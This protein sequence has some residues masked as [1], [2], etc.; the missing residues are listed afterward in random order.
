MENGPLIFILLLVAFVCFIM[1]YDL[2]S[3]YTKL[4]ENFREFMNKNLV[5][6]EFEMSPLHAI[7]YGATGREKLILLDNI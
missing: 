4:E 6:F 5:R 7:V 2:S 1:Y 3:K